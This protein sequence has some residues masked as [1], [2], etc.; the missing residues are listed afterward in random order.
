MPLIFKIGYNVIPLQDVILPTPSSKV[1]KYLIQSG[2]LLPSLKELITSRDKYKPIFISHLGFNQRRIF[3]TN[4]NLKTINKGSRL[5]STIAFS[6]QANV[7]PEVTEGVF[8]TVYGKF[9][10]M[11]ESVEIVEVEKLKEEVEKHMNDNI[12]VRF[13]SPTLLSSKVLLPPSL[14]ERYKRVDAGYSTL[15]SVGLIVAYAYNVYCNLIGKKEVEVRAFKLGVL[16]NALSRIMGYDLHPVTVAIG[17]DS[18]GNLRKARG[19]MGWIE[20]DIPDQKLKR[21]ALRY[22]LASAYLGIGRS[23]GIGFGEIRLEFRKLEEKEKR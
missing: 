22:L 20:F 5:S 13:V 15:P 2:K 17:E 23:R 16:S 9:H 4:G 21:R 19:V 18:K 10:I 6:T 14:S 8:E 11:I 1:L 12:R 3:Q 7:L